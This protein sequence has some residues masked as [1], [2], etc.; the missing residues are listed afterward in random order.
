MWGRDRQPN[1]I[2]LI[3]NSK[4]QLDHDK[5]FGR[6]VETWQKSMFFTIIFLGGC[7]SWFPSLITHVMYLDLYKDSL[8]ESWSA[9]HNLAVYILSIRPLLPECMHAKG[10]ATFLAEGEAMSDKLV[11]GIFD[12]RIG[13]PY[14]MTIWMWQHK[15]F[16]SFLGLIVA[17]PICIPIT[18]KSQKNKK[19]KHKQLYKIRIIQN[20]PHQLLNPIHPYIQAAPSLRIKLSLCRIES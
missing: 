20:S 16:F 15:F 14:R 2:L 12:Q 13:C 7:S 1:Q 6:F 19:I 4:F 5:A 17:R 9:P 10:I 18:F 3:H 11:L 8:R